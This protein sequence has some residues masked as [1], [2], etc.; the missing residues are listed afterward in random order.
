MKVAVLGMGYVG[1]VTA[2]VLA[3]EGHHVVGVDN[4]AAKV[5]MLAHGQ[6]P[7]LEPGLPELMRRVQ[8]AGR[9]TATGDVPTALATAEVVMIAVGTPSAANGGVDVRHVE[10]VSEEIGTV[11]E[12]RTGYPIVVLRS[13]L[14]PD[15]IESCVVPAL[16]R[17]SGKTVGRGFGFALNP[18]FL[19]EGTS[20]QDFDDPQFTLIG[21][22][23]PRAAAVV[24]RLYGFLK[25]PFVV[26]DR[27]TAAFVKYASNAFHAT[28]VAFANEVAAIS[29]TAGVD[30][31]EVMRIL[32]LDQKLNLSAAY[33]RPGMPFGGSCLPKDLR[34]ALSYARRH[35][36]PVPLLDGVLESNRRHTEACVHLILGDGR[37][38]VGILG[39]A[40][41]A[42]TDDLR[43]SPTVEIVERL[44]GKG[45]KVAIYDS[46]VSLA[47]LLGANRAYVTQHLPHIANLLRPTLDDVISDSDVLVMG[48][49]DDDFRRIPELMRPDQT[50]IDLVGIITPR[51]PLAV[52]YQGIGW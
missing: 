42:G 40:F 1:C 49:A 38:R 32:C 31:Q 13:T 34:A 29:K 17:T 9:L 11:L 36:V 46:R 43:E 47:R 28:K 27:R 12:C 10:R 48:N 30:G 8:L 39:L 6:S 44:L 41:K 16:E 20:I 7:V 51:T 22:D 45:A 37:P 21:S 15:T 2:A 35:D 25:A 52:R 26:T 23:E 4:D 5:E 14:L 24:Q 18:E 3:R 50:L 33:L 19:R